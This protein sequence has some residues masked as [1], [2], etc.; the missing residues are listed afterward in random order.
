MTT[1]EKKA[2]I[3]KILDDMP[4]AIVEE[5][6]QFLNEFQSLPIDQQKRQIGLK[7]I[8]EEKRALLLRLAK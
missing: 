4:E 2:E 5:I 1:R 7:R 6:L 8:L 3:I